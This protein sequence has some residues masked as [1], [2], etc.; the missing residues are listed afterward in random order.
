M[1]ATV[2][3]TDYITMNGQ[4]VRGCSR[5]HRLL[6]TRSETLDTLVTRYCM[7][8]LYLFLAKIHILEKS[9]FVR[10]SS[11]LQKCFLSL[12]SFFLCAL[13]GI[14][15]IRLTRSLN[16]CCNTG[17]PTVARS[18]LLVVV[19]LPRMFDESMRILLSGG[20]G[21]F[22]SEVA[23][24]ITTI[25]DRIFLFFMGSRRTVPSSRDTLDVF[26]L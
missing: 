22:A 13:S 18:S 8:T 21:R 3:W 26:I 10:P 19:P 1:I 9:T 15:E 24:E 11:F 6:I 20:A 16:M 5:P 2:V 17:P 23:E 14:V 4:K 12:S 7:Q 25:S